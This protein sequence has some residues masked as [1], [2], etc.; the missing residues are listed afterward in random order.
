[1]AAK[2][3]TM[4]KTAMLS[5][6][7]ASVLLAAPVQAEIVTYRFTTT[8]TSMGD[9]N[10]GT[11]VYT[12]TTSSTFTG[13]LFQLGDTAHG[14]FSYDTDM[15]SSGFTTP[16]WAS[17]IGSTPGTRA[18]LHFDSTGFEY[19]S[20]P[21]DYASIQVTDNPGWD[22][23]SYRLGSSYFTNDQIFHVIARD[24][25]G[26]GLSGPGL[27]PELVPAMFANV[28]FS[29][30]WVRASDRQAMVVEGSFT[31]VERVLDAQVPEPASIGLMLAGLGL[32]GLQ[33]RRAR[34]TN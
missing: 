25:T 28:I 6:L 9:Y 23:F 30:A 20:S 3:T 19:A 18:S 15:P 5:G 12:P 29:Y 26:T 8:I 27:P 7:L 22:D 16:N 13:T 32:V 31:S 21:G 17:Y 34:R 33:R 11:L 4:I 10:F 1:M 24:Y 2:V 14:Q